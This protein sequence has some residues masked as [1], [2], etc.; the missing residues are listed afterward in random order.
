MNMSFAEFSGMFVLFGILF[1][2]LPTILA[3][4]RKKSNKISILI[5]NLLLGWTFIGW[6]VALIWAVSNDQQQPNVIVSQNINNGFVS[7][8]HSDSEQKNCPF[9]AEKIKKEALKCK[10]CGE[11]LPQQIER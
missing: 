1:Y 3:F 10:H 8:E 2:F 5:L 6:L 11:S 9:C 7:Q 4:S